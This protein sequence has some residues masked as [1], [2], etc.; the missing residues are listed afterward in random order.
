MVAFLSHNSI[1]NEWQQRVCFK[2]SAWPTEETPHVDRETE[3]E[4]D[5]RLEGDLGGWRKDVF[6]TKQGEGIGMDKGD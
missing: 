1:K 4:K 5:R 2:P 6:M 3:G